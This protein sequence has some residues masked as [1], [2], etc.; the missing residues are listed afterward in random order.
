M[1]EI[2]LW[3]DTFQ[4]LSTETG[5][6][7]MVHG[8]KN[9]Y[10][11]YLTK[12]TKHNGITIFTDSFLKPVY[13]KSV[14]SPIKIGWLIERREISPIPY[15]LFDS[16]ID[17]L[18]FVMTNDEQLILKYPQKCKF[19]PFGGSWIQDE[20]IRI[21]D[22]TKQISTIFSNKRGILPGYGLRHS[23]ASLVSKQVDMFGTGADK[24]IETKE[25]ALTDY[26]FSIVIENI[27]A[28]NYFTEKLLDCFAVGTIPIYWG[29]PNIGDFFNTDGMVIFNDEKQLVDIVNSIDKINIS[30]K[31]VV[32]N[33]EKS[34]KYI[35]TENW[36]YENILKEIIDG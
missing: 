15:Y 25:E 28:K 4:H 2:N 13:I 26:R 16:Y 32:D 11:K 6:F 18:D 10:L 17:E 36:M 20:N 27:K 31:L 8:K 19:I 7:S 33:F 9:K 35:I 12:K 14:R 3:D 22:K 1:L 24:F 23:V 34:K 5:D 29:C 21:F 30:Q